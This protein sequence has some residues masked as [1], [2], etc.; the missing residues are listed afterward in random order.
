MN[1]L[2]DEKTKGDIRGYTA[3]ASQALLITGPSG[4]GKASLARHIA[5]ELLDIQLEKIENYPYLALIKPV[6]DNISI[7]QIRSLHAF[8]G[9][10]TPGT[11]KIRRVV[12]VEDA[13]KMNVEAQN[14]FLKLL[15]EPPADTAILMTSINERQLLPTVQSRVQKMTLKSP[16][17]EQLESYF[18]QQGYKESEISQA[19]NLSEG[20]LG[21]MAAI[22]ADSSDH[23]LVKA[24]NKA[25]RILAAST[26]ERL[27]M[28]DSLAKDKD[29]LPAVLEALGRIG[30]VMLLQASANGDQQQVKNWLVRLRNI[31][32]SQN[33]LNHNAQPKLMLTNL[34]LNL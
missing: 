1:L 15:E 21:L 11:A 34:F 22:L 26:F 19:Y 8:V 12:I 6:K 7:E 10:K 23:E 20:R 32:Q 29:A 27:N 24:V 9:L 5:A 14:A 13:G 25:K 31:H 17:R 33:A 28:V 16:A 2:I 4:S 18:S 30:R 3:K